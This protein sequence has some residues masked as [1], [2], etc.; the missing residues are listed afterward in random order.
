VLAAVTSGET[1]LMFASMGSTLPFVRNGRLR[2]RAVTSAG[3][4]MEV[5]DIPT[6][7]DFGFAGC[8]AITWHGLLLPAGVPATIVQTLDAHGVRILG[9]PE[10][11]AWLL[12]RRADATPSTPQAFAEY[13]KAKIALDARPV[14][15]SGIRVD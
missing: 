12:T 5:P 15:Q 1:Q 2:P 11:R 10:L 9:Q 7:A 8:E 13:M 4:S 3:C 14:K 6:L